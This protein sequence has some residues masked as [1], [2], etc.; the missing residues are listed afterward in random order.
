VTPIESQIRR[1]SGGQGAPRP[2]V[3]RRD[4]RP[5]LAA[6]VIHGL[7]DAQGRRVRQ[8]RGPGLA[9]DEAA[10]E[11]GRLEGEAAHV[12]NDPAGPL[13][14]DPVVAGGSRIVEP[15]A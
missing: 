14:D 6:Y 4:R 2:C 9:G 10:G 13:V 12:V 15:A 7:H 8:E 5:D 3:I 11:L 1:G